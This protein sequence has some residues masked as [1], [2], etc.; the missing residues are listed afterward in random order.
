MA[1][2][3][4]KIRCGPN[5]RV[6]PLIDGT[7]KPENIELEFES[8]NVAELFYD[9]IRYDEFEL[10]EMSISE[11]LLCMERRAEWGNGRWDWFALPVYL[12]RGHLWTSMHVNSE[13]GIQNAGDLRGRNVGLPDYCM[14]AA[15]WFKATLKDMYGIDAKDVT[16][17]NTRPQGVSQGIELGL[18]DD[19]PPG[20]S[21]NWL[22]REDDP[23]TMVENGEIVGAPSLPANRIENNPKLSALFPDR[24]RELI[25]RFYQETGCFQPNH[26]YII[27]RRIIEENPWVAQSLY[28][29][30]EESKQVAYERARRSR[31]AYL[32]FDEP[33]DFKEQAKVFGEDPYPLGIKA[34]HKT[35]ER[36]IEASLQQGLL[37][38]PMRIEDIYFPTT[39]DS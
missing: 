12:S 2:L 38:K 1:P 22:T 18:V 19:P 25:S 31:A 29:A 5:P 35:L 28:N 3:H 32:Y 27:Q 13:A 7:V 34:M 4:L 23:V 39:L 15:L 11:T 9:N 14:T 33:N 36:L 24:G 26:H 20:I 21:L 10:S 8:K 6:E 16:W 37:R 30:F 17:F